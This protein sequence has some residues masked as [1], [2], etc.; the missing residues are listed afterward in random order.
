M[1][2]RLEVARAALATLDEVLLEPMTKIVRDAA[3][4]RFEC[5]H[6]TIWKAAQAYLAER[7]GE[8]HDTPKS[9]FRA[10]FRAGLLNEDE[11]RLAIEMVDDR[12]RTSH[13]YRESIAQQIY[14]R[15]PAYARLMRLLL[16]RCARPAP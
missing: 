10:S 3:I 8:R 9:V 1:T 11:A 14:G 5:T 16:E 2:T 4:Q 12:N 6:E 7:E 15:L 13:T